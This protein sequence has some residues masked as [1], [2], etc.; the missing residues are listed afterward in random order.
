LGRTQQELAWIVW[1]PF[2]GW[3]IGYFFWGWVAD[4]YLK[5]D[6]RRA[7]RVFVLLA[8][9]ALPEALLP[10][11]HSWPAAIALFC[12]AMFVADGFVV[13]SM[14]VASWLYPR[15]QT[16]LAAGV[17]SGAWSAVLVILLPIYGRWFDFKWFGAIFI[18]MSLLPTAGTILWLLLSRVTRR[19][20]P[21]AVEV[22][23]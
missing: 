11:F 12:W 21:V 6:L 2:V 1:I 5:G 14:R 9:F 10:L 3:E 17:G 8:I 15:D 22:H 13:T 18:T 4:R 23:A 20:T 7:A 19:E 16:A